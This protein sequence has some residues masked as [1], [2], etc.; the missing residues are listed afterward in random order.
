MP[1]VHDSLEHNVTFTPDDGG[2]A[3]KSFDYFGFYM[4]EPTYATKKRKDVLVSLP[5]MDG[6]L[7]FSDVYNGRA[8]F[9]ASEVT[10]RF[11]QQFEPSASGANAMRSMHTGFESFCWG[12]RGTITDDYGAVTLTGARC[13]S[14][15]ATPFPGDNTLTIE[16]TF[17]GVRA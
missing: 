14:F 15:T 4:L 16:V 3:R 5:Y 9:E 11:A 6:E 7:D 17:K 10:Y 13:T 1:N 2:T 12:F 8:Y